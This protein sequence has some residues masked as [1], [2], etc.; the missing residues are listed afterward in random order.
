M[1]VGNISLRTATHTTYNYFVYPF[2]TGDF[3]LACTIRVFASRSVWLCWVFCCRERLY[4][5]IHSMAN[6]IFAWL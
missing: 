2:L 4:T 3:S 5:W 6:T 1:D